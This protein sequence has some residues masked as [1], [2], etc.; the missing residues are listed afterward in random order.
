MTTA[1]QALATPTIER[2]FGATAAAEWQVLLN[3]LELAEEFAL[4]VLVVPDMDGARLCRRELEGWLAERDL[5]LSVIE[6]ATPA[7]LHEAAATL[8]SLPD[9]LACGAVWLAAAYGPSDVDAEA[10]ALAWRHALVGLNQQRNPLRRR[11]PLPLIMVGTSGLVPAMREVAADLWSVRSLSLRIEPGLEALEIEPGYRT[12]LERTET[13]SSTVGPD[14]ELALRMA[15]RLRGRDGQQQALA[16]LLTRAGEGFAARKEWEKAEGAWREAVGLFEQFGPAQA[17]AWVWGELGDRWKITGRTELTREAFAKALAIRERLAREEPER[18]DYQRELSVSNNNMG[19]VYLTLGQGE[20]AREFYRKDLEIT[21]RLAQMEPDRSDY[22]H[23]LLMSY[24]KLSDLYRSLGQ[25]EAAREALA[26]TLAIGERL[27]RKEPDRADYQ[28]DLAVSH[29]KM[30]D[31]YRALGQGEAAREALSKALAISERLAREEPDRADYQHD[32]SVS[33]DEMGDLYRALGQGEA[34]HEAFAKAL[35][36]RERLAD[37]EP[38]RAD[39][40]RGLLVSYIKIGD[41]YR[42]LGQAEAARET[43]VKALAIAE[44]LTRNEPDRADYQRDLSVAHERMGD[45]YC[46]LGQG[47]A[48]RDAFVK[49]LAITERLA[50]K[51]P[52]RVDYQR[53]LSVSYE[54]MGDLYRALGQ[55]DAARDAFTKALAIRERLAR[56]EPDRADYQRDLVVSL[57]RQAQITEGDGARAQLQRALKIVEALQTTARLAQADAEMP[58]ALRQMLDALPT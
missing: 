12:A 47:D 22:Q 36:I 24:G 15:N 38:G 55:G 25:G 20:A 2:R 27:A 32:L 23:D 57:V 1:S 30:G 49:T 16:F 56:D 41:L 43:F 45:L 17:A 18:A 39:Y 51:E 13:T 52:N 42:A 21:A 3:Q 35:A 33:Y 8:F 9:D 54:R 44:R 5:H 19:D 46:A 28:R 48:A 40:Q 11:F 10:W 37:E 4:V 58:S 50:R 14:P 6:P 53:D 7:A 31:L 34:A 29:N 26:K